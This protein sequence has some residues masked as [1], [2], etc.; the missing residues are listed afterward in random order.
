M[1][2]IT[3]FGIPDSETSSDMSVEEYG[4]IFQALVHS[5]EVAENVFARVAKKAFRRKVGDIKFRESKDARGMIPMWV[6]ESSVVLV[7]PPPKENQDWLFALDNLVD[8]LAQ[9]LKS[10]TND[11]PHVLVDSLSVRIQHVG[12]E[13]FR[14]IIKQKWAL[15]K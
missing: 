6:T 9:H 11:R 2:I 7:R 5:L 14:F 10:S 1:R 3:G 8:S 4:Q 15:E 12:E 13:I